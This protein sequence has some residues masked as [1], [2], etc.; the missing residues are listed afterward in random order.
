VGNHTA[1]HHERSLD[2]RRIAIVGRLAGMSRRKVEQ[3]VRERGGVFVG[4]VDVDTDLVVVG[5]DAPEADHIVAAPEWTDDGARRAWQA[6]RL[7]FV[8]ESE[9]WARLGFVDSG[10]EVKRFYT[11][12]MLAELVRVPVPAIRRWHRQRHL[13]AAQEVGRLAYFDFEEVRVARRLAELLSAKC[14]LSQIDRKLAELARLTPGLPRPLADPAVVVIGRRLYV[15]RGENLAEPSGQLLMDFE[16]SA[17][18]SVPQQH[19]ASAATIP[20][21]TLTDRHVGDRDRIAPTCKSLSAEDL[22]SLAD[23]FEASGQAEQAIEVYRTMLMSGV[24]SADVHFCLAELLYRSGDL[25]GARER[26]Y[27]AIELDEDYVEARANLGCVLAEEGQIPLAEAAFRGALECHADF[28]DAH[29]HLARLLDNTGQ[30]ADAAR[31]WQRFLDLAPAS[32]WAEEAHDRTGGMPSSRAGQLN[33][34]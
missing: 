21:D 27:A 34:A 14:S 4:T 32:P 13:R 19:D 3:L 33:D 25:G 2:G 20:M 28:A 8:R 26:Y 12:A 7:Q 11:P 16:A 10:P 6:G 18:S 29:Y 31:H 23:D 15:R 5:D 24:R 17:G 30:P 22:Q 9:F 1:D